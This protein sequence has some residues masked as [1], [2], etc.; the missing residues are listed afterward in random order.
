MPD[1]SKRST[2]TE[3][4]DD[5]GYTGA[6]MDRTLHEL[7]IINRVLGGNAVTLSALRKMTTMHGR[8][9]FKIADLGCG[10]GD[11][12]SII[13]AWAKKNKQPIELT[14]IDGNEYVIDAARKNLKHLPEIKLITQNIL[15]EDFRAQQFDIVIGTLFF[16]H[17]T[18]DELVSFFSAMKHNTSVGFIINDIHRH[19]IAYHAI[20]ILTALLSGSSM[21]KFDAPLSVLRAFKKAELENILTRSGL[22]NFAIRWCW[23]FRWQVIVYTQE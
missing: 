16:H 15:A 18:D 17:F 2:A 21:V 10:R 4:M 11:M 14:G 6:L 8:P 19:P 20:R 1:Y 9:S 5:L 12:L 23:A 3:I 13:R 22:A 7:E